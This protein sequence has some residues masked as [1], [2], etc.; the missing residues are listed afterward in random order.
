MSQPVHSPSSS[1]A[2]LGAASML[3]AA[4]LAKSV[5][6]ARKLRNQLLNQRRTMESQSQ[7]IKMLQ[8]SE[9]DIV[10][11]LRQQ[12]R[13]TRQELEK[14]HQETTATKQQL[15]KALR[16]ITTVKNDLQDTQEAL[17]QARI[18]I[19]SLQSELA[20]KQEPPAPKEILVQDPRIMR[21]LEDTRNQLQNSQDQVE[22][23]LAENKQHARKAQLDL[24]KREDHL[25]KLYSN[26]N[27]QQQK[28]IKIK[29]K[30]IHE[31]LEKKVSK[32]E[33]DT[34]EAKTTLGKVRESLVKSQSQVK[35]QNDQ[36][37]SYAKKLAEAKTKLERSDTT[38]ATRLKQ[39]RADYAAKLTEKEFEVE[40]LR[41][42]LT[43]RE[44][45]RQETMRAQSPV[46]EIF[47]PSSR[48]SSIMEESPISIDSA[49]LY[50][51]ARRE[52][53]SEYMEKLSEGNYSDDTDDE[54][55]STGPP[56]W[57]LVD[58]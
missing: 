36:I 50:E 45:K 40:K 20:T 25:K 13:E 51:D 54:S 38:C 5:Y 21:T 22:K 41:Q 26:R 9:S 3:G 42:K 12:L 23:L 15:D 11:R 49:K 31:E 52:F 16:E 57:T 35:S 34:V 46:S 1:S 7:R 17:N 19:I 24:K 27:R 8:S 2:I 14:A 56:G 33:A 29:E 39:A 44:Q 47:T 6:D 30:Y 58:E 43:T 18:H 48:P 32:A 4:G 37:N 55:P 10:Q 53:G 28:R